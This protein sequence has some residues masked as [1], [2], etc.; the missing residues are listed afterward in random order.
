MKPTLAALLTLLVLGSLAAC[1]YLFEEADLYPAGHLH[2]A[3]VFLLGLM[4]I[5]GLLLAR[6]RR[7][8]GLAAFSTGALLIALADAFYP[9]LW[10]RAGYATLAGVAISQLALIFF[11]RNS[12]SSTVR[13]FLM[14]AITMAVALLPLLLIVYLPWPPLAVQI[15]VGVS[16]A[17]IVWV[18]I[19]SWLSRQRKLNLVQIIALVTSLGVLAALI[20][21]SFSSSTFPLQRRQLAESALFWSIITLLAAQLT[22]TV[23][24]EKSLRSG[25]HMSLDA[26]MKDALT[27]L[28][29]RRALE[30]YGPRLINQSFEAGRPVSLII[31][32]VDHFKQM[33]DLN[34]HQ[35]GDVVLQQTAPPLLGQVRKS[36]LVARYGGEEFVILL[37]GSPL[38]PA[39]RLA[40]KM[41]HAISQQEITYEGKTLRRTASFGVASAF[42]EE[43]AAL[44]EL[45]ERADQNL[46]RAKREGRN[47]VLA[48][49]LVHEDF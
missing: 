33:N 5:N 8:C 29:N 26:S 44:S 30:Y 11:R 40:E 23:Q 27:G 4:G 42:P 32:D 47:R 7:A 49:A 31:C 39:L 35:A 22:D 45:I 36:D 18:I 2:E 46:Y 41:R 1:S 34:G 28:A 43:P 19:R 17:V 25:P 15:V 21:A 20:A 48:D 9:D 38:A 37:P 6:T 24:S 12:D 13:Y 10:L 3:T 14:L 16:A